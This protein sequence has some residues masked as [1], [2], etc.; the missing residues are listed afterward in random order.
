VLTRTKIALAAALL[1]L[2]STAAMA[3]GFFD[4]NLANRYPAYDNPGVYGYTADGRLTTQLNPAH[5]GTLQSAPVQLN[6][7]DTPVASEAFVPQHSRR[8]PGNQGDTSYGQDWA[9]T[10]GGP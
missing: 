10:W 2:T 1:A 6:T 8:V 5:Q 4:P 7:M 9:E 3:Q